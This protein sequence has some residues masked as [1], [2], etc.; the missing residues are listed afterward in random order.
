[1]QLPIKAPHGAVPLEWK[2]LSVPV[3]YN[4]GMCQRL[5]WMEARFEQLML[6][7]SI[8]RLYVFW[9]QRRLDFEL[10]HTHSSLEAH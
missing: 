2:G 3:T 4:A 6:N 8:P 1:M 7:L 5:I 10:L 9:A